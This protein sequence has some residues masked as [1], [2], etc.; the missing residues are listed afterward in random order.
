MHLLSCR[1]DLIRLDVDIVVHGHADS[2]MSCDSLQGFRIGAC[3]CQVGQITM[4]QYVGCCTMQINR[5]LDSAPCVVKHGH[6]DRRFAA[7]NKTFFLRWL[8]RIQHIGVQRDIPIA[9]GGL[10][11]ADNRLVAACMGKQFRLIE[12]FVQEDSKAEK[13]CT[14]TYKCLLDAFAADFEGEDQ[15]IR[16]D[17]LGNLKGRNDFQDHL[18]FA[19]V[20]LN[21]KSP[22]YYL[23]ILIEQNPDLRKKLLDPQNCQGEGDIQIIEGYMNSET[24]KSA[25]VNDLLA[26]I[27]QNI[28]RSPIR[29]PSC[30]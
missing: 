4:P 30:K 13:I 28:F 1:L 5:F 19:Q 14:F 9:F 16:R 3:T 24:Y 27:E 22:S 6:R 17:Y 20:G 12:K 11:S 8:Q 26:D 10:G 21:Y 23:S 15:E 18:V 7:D 2:R 29:N 25:V